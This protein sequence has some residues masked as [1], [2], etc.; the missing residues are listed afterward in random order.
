[1][2][3]ITKLNER[4]EIPIE[5]PK[6]GRGRPKAEDMKVTWHTFIAEDGCNLETTIRKVTAT[7]K[8]G[9]NMEYKK[10]VRK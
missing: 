4:Y 10:T 9:Y 7:C 5:K 8:H 2:P 1:M 6:R 3:K